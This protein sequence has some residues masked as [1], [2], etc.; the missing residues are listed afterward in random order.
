V[1]RI[2]ASLDAHSTHPIACAIV[3]R[4]REE[5]VLLS[6]ASSVTALGGRGVRGIVDGTSALVGNRR[7]FAERALMSPTLDAQLDAIGRTG[8]TAVIVAVADRPL[9]VIAVADELRE[10][11]PDTIALLR[12]QGIAHVAMLTG[13]Y[14]GSAAAVA[15]A[16]QVD[17]CRAELLPQDKVDA[18]A[19]LRAQHG[20]VAM[21]GD[22]VNDAPALAA[23]DVGIAMGA[24]GSDAALETADIALMADE[25][26]KIPYAFRLS[27]ATLATI[28][29]NIA[30]ALTLKAVFL[31]MAIGGLATLWMAVLADTG[32]SL[33][34]IGNGLRLLRRD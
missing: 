29:T 14:R 10:T 7:L 22:G 6:A 30:F 27:R 5:G 4:A 13:D 9:G 11:S 33:L 15:D 28:R 21:I 3:R 8:Q 24:A 18:I 12:E 19:A 23:A 20:A 25:L 34:V 17:D 1:L 16:V 32:A 31:V 2:A 26:L